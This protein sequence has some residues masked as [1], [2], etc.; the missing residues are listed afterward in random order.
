MTQK[1][2]DGVRSFLPAWMRDMP[3]L[4]FPD[5]PD[6]FFQL[7]DRHQLQLL[8]K[9]KNL[10]PE[11]VARIERDLDLL[12]YELLRLFR[13]RDMQA[14]AAHNRH[15]VNTLVFILLG[16]MSILLGTLV[17]VALATASSFVP[18]LSFLVTLLALIMTF[19][20]TI[21]GR[22]TSITNWYG[23]RRRA[24]MLR[25]EY[26]R[27]LMR[28]PPYHEGDDYQL[29]LTLSR[30]AAEVNRGLAVEEDSLS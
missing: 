2:P 3:R 28:L 22:E 12:E 17:A 9:D 15:R 14:K 27:F 20:A 29:K 26:F 5:Q 13:D 19:T 7:V 25:R 8:A 30:R 10:D 16:V 1:S 21:S 18:V 11:A 4:R 24:E 23:N 6:A